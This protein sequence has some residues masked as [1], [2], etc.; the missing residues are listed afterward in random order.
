MHEDIHLTLCQVM[1]TH[2]PSVL[3]GTERWIELNNWIGYTASLPPSPSRELE[4]L[5]GQIWSTVYKI[6][7]VAVAYRDKQEKQSNVHSDTGVD[8]REERS[9]C[10]Q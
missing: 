9:K 10:I 4:G 3:I 5:A 1:D 2:S 7:T 6:K 8:D